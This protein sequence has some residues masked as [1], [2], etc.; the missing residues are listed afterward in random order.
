[1]GSWPPL[2]LLI[3]GYP[4]ESIQAW[5]SVHAFFTAFSPNKIYGKTL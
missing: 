2:Q 3:F 5:T 4:N 1:L